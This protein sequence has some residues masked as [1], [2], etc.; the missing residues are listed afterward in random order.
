MLLTHIHSFRA[1]A[2]QIRFVKQLVLVQILNGEALTN[3]LG[4]EMFDRV[5]QHELFDKSKFTT[6]FF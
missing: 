5:Y 4:F 2:S 3:E 1:T 6:F